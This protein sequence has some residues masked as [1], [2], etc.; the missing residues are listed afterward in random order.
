MS[1]DAKIVWLAGYYGYD[2]RDEVTGVFS[3]EAAA[4]AHAE[5]YAGEEGPE[6]CFY[7]PEVI[8]DP[9]A[10]PGFER[11]LRDV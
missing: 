8:D 2:A 3:S 1:D 4:R 11:T 7:Y 5:S 9:D 10:D 6:N